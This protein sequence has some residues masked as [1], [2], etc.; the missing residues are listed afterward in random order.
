MQLVE[1]NE[2]S[3]EGLVM[4]ASHVSELQNNLANYSSMIDEAEMSTEDG[5]ALSTS[6][7]KHNSTATERVKNLE[8][9]LSA[10]YTL[11]QNIT[12]IQLFI[13]RLDQTLSDYDI[14]MLYQQ[15]Q[16]MLSDQETMRQSLETSLQS[17][18]EQV[19]YLEHV[20]SLLPERCT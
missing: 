10:L 1:R 12:A 8:A 15:L 9:D 20:N 7:Q 11:T 5:I 14:L 19:L 17:L 16:N 6:L 4:N 13:E 2:D 3:I 18:Q